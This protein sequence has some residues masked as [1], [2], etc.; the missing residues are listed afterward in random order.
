MP[1]RL[2]TRLTIL[3]PE[4]VDYRAQAM[5][6]RCTDWTRVDPLGHR[7][8]RGR[9]RHFFTFFGSQSFFFLAETKPH[10]LHRQSPG[11]ALRIGFP[12]WQLIRRS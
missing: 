1:L 7:P 5:V 10:S 12:F 6:G 2:L 9:S 3:R 11:L 8:R 4:P